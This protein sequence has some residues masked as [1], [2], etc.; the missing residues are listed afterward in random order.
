MSTAARIFEMVLRIC[1]SGA[2]ILGLAFWLGYG[3]SWTQL[4][5]RLGLAIVAT[6]WMLAAMA[7]RTGAPAG[8]VAFAA[9]WGGLTWYL[10][11]TQRQLLPG[12][13]HW[14]VAVAHLLVGVTAMGLG[15]RLARQVGSRSVRS[16]VGV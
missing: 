11:V 14:I 1:G 15:G 2:L 10:G 5:I 16:D 12:S 6:L 8:L 4:H 7:W 3:R 13:L 9:A